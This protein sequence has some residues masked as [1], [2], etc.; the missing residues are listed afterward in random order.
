ME[1]KIQLNSAEVFFSISLSFLFGVSLA[2]LNLSFFYFVV[3]GF[4]FLIILYLIY[5]GPIKFFVIFGLTIFI[6]FFYFNF[7][8]YLKET[9]E[10]AI[11]SS[12]PPFIGVVIESTSRENQQIILS[13]KGFSSKIKVITELYPKFE[14]GDLVMVDGKIKKLDNAFYSLVIYFPKIKII[15][16]HQGEWVKE[17]LFRIKKNFEDQFKK[18][19]PS[20]SAALLEGLIFGSRANFSQ[21]FKSEMN[22]SGTAHLVAL[23]GYN[24]AILIVAISQTLGHFLSRR[25]TFYFS[26]IVVSLFVIMVGG[27]ASVVRAA[28]MGFLFIFAREVGRLYNPKNAIVLAALVM[29][30]I[31]PFLIKFDRGFLLSFASLLGVVYLAPALEKLFKAKKESNLIGGDKTN[32]GFLS[33]KENAITTLSAQL[34]VLPIVITSFGQFSLTS[35]LANILILEFIPLTMFLGFLLSIFGFISYLSG[36]VIAKLVNLLLIYEIKVIKFFANF[37]L[38]IKLTFNSFY[39]FLIYY[40]AIVCF[41]VYFHN[42]K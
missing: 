26:A 30:L 19:L 6:G 37:S 23:S 42:K 32:K 15:D 16:K 38:L 18:F 13:L 25:M 21:E 8:F 39:A 9:A 29:I 5:R 1:K 27:E 11:L 33:W 35:I 4:S 34:A 20:N 41:I 28:I 40:L 2:S 24:I 10:N 22:K 31:N 7:R 17:N 3:A 12:S 36:F 14:Y